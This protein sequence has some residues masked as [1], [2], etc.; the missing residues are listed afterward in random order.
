MGLTLSMLKK[1]HLDYFMSNQAVI[2]PIFDNL[3]TD[4]L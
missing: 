1:Y 4:V 2:M 3:H